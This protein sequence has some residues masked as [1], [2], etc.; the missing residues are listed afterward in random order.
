MNYYQKYLKYKQKY[1]QLQKMIGG[2]KTT[3]TD[4]QC[5]PDDV[6]EKCIEQDIERIEGYD[7]VNRDIKTKGV[8]FDTLKIDVN[9]PFADYNINKNSKFDLR[10]GKKP[11]LRPTA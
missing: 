10:I 5:E 1:L 9:R 3:L 6:I 4:L 2:N 11:M 8:Y 7:G